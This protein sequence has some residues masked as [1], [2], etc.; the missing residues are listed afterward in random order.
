MAIVPSRPL[1]PGIPADCY[2]ARKLFED[3]TRGLTCG[4]LLHVNSKT[5]S[6]AYFDMLSVCLFGAAKYFVPFYVVRRAERQRGR[7]VIP[8]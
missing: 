4:D 6:A 7:V 5:C 1:P 2:G 8:K 3:A